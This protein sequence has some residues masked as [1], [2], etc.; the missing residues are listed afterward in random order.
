ML[1]AIEYGK[2]NHCKICFDICPMG[3]FKLMGRMV[4]IAYPRDCMSCMLCEMDC[5]RDCIEISA[6]RARTAVLPY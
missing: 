5:P 4:Y 2:C 6:W 1:T 3:C